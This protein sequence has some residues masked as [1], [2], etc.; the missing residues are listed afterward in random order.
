MMTAKQ[1]AD[2]LDGREYGSEI[3]EAEAK[4]AAESGLV[5][6]FG[7]TKLRDLGDGECFRF[8]GYDWIALDRGNPAAVYGTAGYARLCLMADV[9]KNE[10]FDVDNS[11]D[12]RVSS[13][14]KYLNGKFLNELGSNRQKE[15]DA[16]PS[17]D[18]VQ[19]ASGLTAEDG[20]KDY[21]TSEDLVFLLSAND[22]RRNRYSIPATKGWWWL[23]TPYSTPKSGYTYVVRAVG[24]SGTLTLSDAHCGCNGLRPAIYLRENTE[25]ETEK[26]Q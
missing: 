21:G 19:Y 15:L 2:L 9:L 8:G 25:V 22:Y 5:V 6:V 13:A 14:R 20:L 26:S 12:W 3:T 17:L 16:L 10:P 24:V 18:L 4:E 23:I 7:K 1:L 11:N